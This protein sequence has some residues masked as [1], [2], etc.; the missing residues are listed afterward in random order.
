MLAAGVDELSSGA[1]LYWLLLPNSVVQAHS[2][3]TPRAA[4]RGD[5]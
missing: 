1:A 2:A 5:N 3:E 4:A